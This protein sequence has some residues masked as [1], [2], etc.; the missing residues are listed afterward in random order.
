VAID[1]NAFIREFFAYL[2]M[3]L[4]WVVLFSIPTNGCFVWIIIDRQLWNYIFVVIAYL[5]NS[6]S[7][8][9]GPNH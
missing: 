6:Q 3:Q 4:K 8:E 1:A 5:S 2:Y 9:L 7:G